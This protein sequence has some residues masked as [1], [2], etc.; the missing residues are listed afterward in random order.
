MP[1][2]PRNVGLGHPWV[3][4]ADP[5]LEDANEKVLDVQK[6][7]GTS[8]FNVDAEGDTAFTGTGTFT[9][10]Q[11]LDVAKSAT[12]GSAS[13]NEMVAAGAAAGVAPTITATGSDADVGLNLVPKGAGGVQIGGGTLKIKTAKI[14]KLSVDPADLAAQIANRHGLAF[15]AGAGVTAASILI[16]VPA[17][18]L[19]ADLVV[20][21][22]W[23]T[24]ADAGAVMIH[25]VAAIN[26]AAKDWHFIVLEFV[27]V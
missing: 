6:G 4:R 17:A 23:A 12:I 3:L 21:H 24:G 7:D 13:A 10:A 22:A 15:P 8:L 9:L 5:K 26:G 27:A 16:P 25:S 20:G 18:T 11:A 14:V 2:K 19:E 1:I